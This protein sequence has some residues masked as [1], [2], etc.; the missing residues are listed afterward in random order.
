MGRAEPLVNFEV[1]LAGVDMAGKTASSRSNICQAQVRQE[2]QVVW[3][4]SA[5]L[6]VVDLGV[7][8]EHGVP[9]IPV[10]LHG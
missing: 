4:R 5:Y 1:A 8:Y 3:N 6:L 2:S 9:V 10:E 7:R